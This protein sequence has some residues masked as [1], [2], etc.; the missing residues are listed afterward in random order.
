VVLFFAKRAAAYG[1]TVSYSPIRCKMNDLLFGNARILKTVAD[2]EDEV[3]V[4]RE[5][6]VWR[7][8]DTYESYFKVVD[9]IVMKLFNLPI[10]DQ[11]KRILDTGCDN[12]AFLEL[13]YAIIEK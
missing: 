8:S 5:M 1:V 2:A 13:V 3:N 11:S 10:E 4:H 12:V 9:K 6:N 7:G